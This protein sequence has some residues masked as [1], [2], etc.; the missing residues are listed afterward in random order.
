MLKNCP[1]GASNHDGRRHFVAA[2]A[3]IALAVNT[4]LRAAPYPAE[5][6]LAV[7][8]V[9]LPGARAAFAA[10][11][12]L[13]ARRFAAQAVRP[14][15]VFIASEQEAKP[16]T[17]EKLRRAIADSRADI[18]LASNDG[19]ADLLRT[20][21]V[22]QPILFFTA[23]DPV[24]IGLT[25]S[26][27]QPRLG[28]TG[29]ALGANSDLKRGEMLMR[30]APRS[31][32]VGHLS[33]AGYAQ[34]GNRAPA[35]SAPAFDGVV[36]RRFE[37]DDPARLPA[38]LA[39]AEARRVDAWDVGYS[40]AVFRH[41]EAVVAALSALRRPTMYPRMKF[42]QMG[43][44]AAFE[45]RIDE[46]DAAWVAQVALLLAG[47]PIEKIPVIQAT[48]YRF[49]INLRVCRRLGIAPP[50]SLIKTADVVLE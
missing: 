23:L 5:P 49:G 3:C 7:I 33:T 16:A 6:V 27:T 34:D 47:V 29:F 31:H 43:G 38:M 36:V 15:C 28:M 4:Q 45:P 2:A 8:D 30:L 32:V 25:D 14:R 20:L 24:A 13:V 22:H 50:K 39:S 26:L 48:R 9:D 40:Y 12:A 42:L 35:M 1:A 46:A 11:A 44:M 17:F 10:F 41:S 18:L 21:K 37:F 19:F